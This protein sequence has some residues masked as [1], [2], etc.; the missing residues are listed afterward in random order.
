MQKTT[1]TSV[2]EALLFISLLII[3]AQAIAI[4]VLLGSIPAST[5]F[6]GFATLLGITVHILVTRE[7]RHRNSIRKLIGFYPELIFG[8]LVAFL[9]WYAFSNLS[10]WLAEATPFFAQ[11]LLLWEGIPLYILLGMFSFLGAYIPY[12]LVRPEVRDWLGLK[13]ND[14]IYDA[15]ELLKKYKRQTGRFSPEEDIY[16]RTKHE[17]E[18]P[19]K[20][21]SV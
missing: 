13:R 18:S 16:D 9:A 6:S 8:S 4:L 15:L 3:V 17:K 12:F 10:N 21:A 14:D 11:I 1:Q 20:G 5:F 19:P 7:S 2:S